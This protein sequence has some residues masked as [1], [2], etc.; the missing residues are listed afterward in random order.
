MAQIERA[1][2][3]TR[4]AAGAATERLHARLPP[5]RQGSEAV[6]A[7][8]RGVAGALEE[9]RA[10]TGLISALEGSGRQ[11]ERIVGGIALVA[12]Q[13]NMLAVSGAVEAARAGEAGRGFAVVSGDIRALARDAGENAG[14][15]QDLVRGIQDR[16]AAVRRDL[17]ASVAASEIAAAR[18]HALIDRLAAV[19][20]EMEQLQGGAAETLSGAEA[21][22]VSVRDVL[23]GTQQIATA[24]EEASGAASQAAVAAREQARGAEDLAAAIEEIAS[25]ADELQITE[26]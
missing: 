25:L 8:S 19:A 20:G 26:G 15:M 17:D 3:A 7:L 16:I 10:V 14:Q 18:S 12:V 2:A 22:L 6:A 1:A 21:V 23:A 5:L 4:A 11:I 9:T 13:T 24:A